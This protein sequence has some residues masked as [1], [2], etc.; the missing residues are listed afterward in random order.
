MTTIPFGLRMADPG[1]TSRLAAKFSIPWAEAAALVLGRAD[2]AAFEPAVLD[3]ARSTT[4]KG[5]RPGDNRS[6]PA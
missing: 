2:L 6:T 3:D 5:N 1:P 4:P